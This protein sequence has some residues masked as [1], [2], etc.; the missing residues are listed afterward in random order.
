MKYRFLKT[1][2]ALLLVFFLTGC[3]DRVEIENR[4]FVLA[5]AIDKEMKK[6]GKRLYELTIQVAEPKALSYNF[7]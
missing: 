4:I 2:I 3:W 1:I 5:V 7:V 6:D